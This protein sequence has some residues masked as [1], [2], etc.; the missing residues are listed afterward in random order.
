MRPLEAELRSVLGR[1]EPPEG[2]VERVLARIIGR[3]VVAVARRPLAAW[4]GRRALL[5]WATAAA[6]ACLLVMGLAEYHQRREGERAK[7]RVMLA[8]H[9]ASGQ[10]NGTLED[11]VQMNTSQPKGQSRERSLEKKEPLL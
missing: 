8:L 11:V 5:G 4:F 7:A 6:L 2:F 1:K 9:I 3:P 10:L